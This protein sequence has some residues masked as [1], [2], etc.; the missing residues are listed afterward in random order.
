MQH[1]SMIL[2]GPLHIG[3]CQIIQTFCYN[4]LSELLQ[5]HLHFMSYFGIMIGA[6]NAG[7][8]TEAER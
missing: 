1:V 7:A 4:F 3:L 6:P 5:S 2:T 8:E